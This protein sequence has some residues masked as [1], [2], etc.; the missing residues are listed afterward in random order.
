MITLKG[1]DPRMIANNLEPSNLIH[2]G[3][4]IKDEIESRGMTQKRLA[5]MTGISMSALNE[6]LNG[7]RSVTIE[8]ALLLEAALGIDADIWIGLQA[9][10]D[11]QKACYDKSFLK[12]LENIRKSAAML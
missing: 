2:P 7:K 11:K 5:D 4:M 9:D 10:Y 12:R 8:Y 6:V 3:E 1:I